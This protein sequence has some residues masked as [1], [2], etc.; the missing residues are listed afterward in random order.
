MGIVRSRH[1]TMSESASSV[2]ACDHVSPEDLT[3]D[4]DEVTSELCPSMVYDTDG[5]YHAIPDTYNSKPLFRKMCPQPNELRVARIVQAHPHPNVVEIYHAC[6]DYIDME[7][8]QT[9]VI[10][11]LQDIERAHAYLLKHNIVYMDWKPDNF[12]VDLNG[13]TKVFDF[14]S[15]GMFDSETDT[16]VY[17]PPSYWSMRKATEAG[18][19]NPSDIDRYTF[20]ERKTI[21]RYIRE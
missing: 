7:L 16:W 6:E 19:T 18:H 20:D 14:D 2:C 4:E 13:I 1:D 10:Y 12:G 5:E 17:C 8:L 9:G 3:F 21:W 15:S 11:N